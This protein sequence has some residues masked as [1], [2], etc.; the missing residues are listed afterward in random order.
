[1][2][3][4]SDGAGSLRSRAS[5]EVTTMAL[6][7]PAKQGRGRS[8]AS[9]GASAP[10]RLAGW[11][12]VAYGATRP[13]PKAC[14]PCAS[15]RWR[16]SSGRP[17]S[18]SWALF[19]HP[20]EL[21]PFAVSA[22]RAPSRSRSRGPP[23][24]G[25]RAPMQA[26]W[27]RVLLGFTLAVFVPVTAARAATAAWLPSGPAAAAL[28]GVAAP[29]SSTGSGPAL[30]YLRAVGRLGHLRHAEDP[31]PLLQA[32]LTT[33][34][35][36][37]WG[38]RERFSRLPGR[39]RRRVAMV[40]RSVP[41][42]PMLSPWRVV[43]LIRLGLPLCLTSLLTTAWSLP[44]GC[45]WG[46]RRDRRPG[47]L[48]LRRL[49][50]GSRHGPRQ[51]RPRRDLPRVYRGAAAAGLAETTRAHTSR[52]RSGPSRPCLPPLAGLGA[53]GSGRRSPGRCALRR[54]GA[55]GPALRLCGLAQ[56]LATLAALTD[57]TPPS[58]SGSGPLIASGALVV[59]VLASAAPCSMRSFGLA[60]CRRRR[61]GR[62]AV[63]AAGRV[64]RWCR[65]P[66][67][68]SP[69]RTA[70]AA[71]SSTPLAVRRRRPVAA[72]PRSSGYAFLRPRVSGSSRSS[73]ALYVAAGRASSRPHTLRRL[74]RAPP[75]A[76]RR[77]CD[78]RRGS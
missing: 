8:R 5:R 47:P 77:C 49:A 66:A 35:R 63:G 36:L 12:A 67:S 53:L 46:P 14:S 55:G 51:R 70:L 65:S 30:Y 3:R 26:A 58:A 48:R 17:V 22:R 54:R 1:L 10:I 31:E 43:R 40:A 20:D 24:W 57:H 56:G 59:T 11:E 42:R 21:L 71:S 52:A 19:S 73:C 68:V 25:G 60:G 23:G 38:L 76:A 18:A 32:I 16:A 34:S 33:A 75:E 74:E 4:T 15:S 28:G 78:V 6:R 7:R 61:A 62:R 72:R 27:G 29:S 9:S 2:S 64:H 44:T 50:G 39:D 45:S 37:T 41:M 13:S 69:L